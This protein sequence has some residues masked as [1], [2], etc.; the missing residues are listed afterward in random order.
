[1]N[2]RQRILSEAEASEILRAA[3]ELQEASGT[4]YSAGVTV[5]ELQRIASEAGISPEFLAQAMRAPIAKTTT[6]SPLRL[7][8]ETEVVV[9]GEIAPENLDLLLSELKSKG[10]VSQFQQ[11]GRSL[12][13]MVNR[14]PM[15][16]RVELVSRGGR[17]RVKV[18]SIPF[19]P[20]FLGLHAPLIAACVAGPAVGSHNPL[21][22][23]AVAVGTFVAG[24]GLF[25]LFN[26]ISLQKSRELASWLAEEVGRVANEPVPAKSVTSAQELTE[27]LEQGS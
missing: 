5:E 17:T 13:A 14:V 19:M 6:T 7:S 8:Q 1:M 27:R 12:S 20:Y 2:E 15:S 4:D 25:S 24:L 3:A 23:V 21:A 22:G 11:V 9:D 18:K 16:A 26:K 10:G